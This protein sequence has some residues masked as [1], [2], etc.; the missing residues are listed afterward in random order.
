MPRIIPIIERVEAIVDKDSMKPELLSEINFFRGLVCFFKNDGKRSLEFLTKAMEMLPK[1][2]Y[3]ALRSAT[4]Y[5][6]SFALHQNGQ[7]E[8]AISRLHQGILNSDSQEGYLMS[9]LL[10]GLCFTPL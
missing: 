2:A 7:K 10:F 5:F 3:L 1:G 9:R 6:L 4:E 8:T